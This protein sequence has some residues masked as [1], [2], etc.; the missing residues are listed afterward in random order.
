[1]VEKRTKSEV[2]ETIRDA[3]RNSKKS[4]YALSKETGIDQG[5]LSRFLDGQNMGLPGLE[6]IAANLGL[7]IIVRPIKT[8]RGGK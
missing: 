3:I 6:A 1:M 5:Q 4:R 7:E 8:K 2:A